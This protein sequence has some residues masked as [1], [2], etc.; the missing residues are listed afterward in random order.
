MC[1]VCPALQCDGAGCGAV[2][3]RVT[4]LYNSWVRLHLT[5]TGRAVDDAPSAAVSAAPAATATPADDVHLTPTEKQVYSQLHLTLCKVK[6]DI[7]E[8]NVSAVDY[9]YNNNNNNN[10]KAYLYTGYSS[11]SLSVILSVSQSFSN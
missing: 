7:L 9:N 3:R 1:D 8:Y 6:R 4:A 11:V 5:L 2:V 10:N